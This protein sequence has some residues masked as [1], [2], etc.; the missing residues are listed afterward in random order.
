[1]CAIG[2]GKKRRFDDAEEEEEDEDDKEQ[3]QAES[4]ESVAQKAVQTASLALARAAAVKD[5]ECAS[6]EER[7]AASAAAVE[8]AKSNIAKADTDLCRAVQLNSDADEREGAAKRK[9]QDMMAESFTI[10][11]FRNHTFALAVLM[12]A[13]DAVRDKMASTD[14]VIAAEAAVTRSKRDLKAAH[15]AAGLPAQ[16]AVAAY[17]AADAALKAAVKRFVEISSA[18]GSTSATNSDGDDVVLV[19]RDLGLCVIC[20]DPI[21]AGTF[22]FECPGDGPGDTH[23]MHQKCMDG[24]VGTILTQNEHMK[25]VMKNGGRG[26]CPGTEDGACTVQPMLRHASLSKFHASQLAHERSLRSS[27]AEAEIRRVAEEADALPRALRRYSEML[28]A[29]PHCPNPACRQLIHEFDACFKVLCEACGC[30]HCGF[31]YS[32]ESLTQPGENDRNHRHVTECAFRLGFADYYASP[33]EKRRNDESDEAYAA[34]CN[35]TREAAHKG[36]AI[37][38][39]KVHVP[40]FLKEYPP[41]L[42]AAVLQRVRAEDPEFAA[43]GVDDATFLDAAV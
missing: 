29:K 31:C 41:H 3:E 21:T 37:A 30:E 7:R 16:K 43:L 22:G 14:G 33:L 36:A 2:A 15:E 39:A 20:Q 1:M 27:A 12:E 19:P 42:R 34:R 11:G 35:A 17:D 28:P 23:Q 5:R 10:S 32:Q 25:A 6:L 8:E 18:G 26:P 40:A 9:I 38:Y 13:S 4:A 24:W